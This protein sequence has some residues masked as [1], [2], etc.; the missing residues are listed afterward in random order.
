[1]IDP[2]GHNITRK[3]IPMLYTWER[4]LSD[5]VGG[6]W[7]HPLCEQGLQATLSIIVI[8][9]SPYRGVAILIRPLEPSPAVVAIMASTLLIKLR[10][11]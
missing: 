6:G 1:M 2:N 9:S 11:P 5:G 8:P 10:I 7:M 3:R 4:S